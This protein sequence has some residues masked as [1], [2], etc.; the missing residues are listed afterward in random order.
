VTVRRRR[1]EALAKVTGTSRRASGWEDEKIARSGRSISPHP[2]EE[3]M[4]ELG[5][6]IQMDEGLFMTT[7]TWLF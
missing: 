4:S 5:G 6:I 2:L 1:R 7:P 3:K